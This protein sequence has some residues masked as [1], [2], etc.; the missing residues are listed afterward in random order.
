MNKFLSELTN[1]KKM[2]WGNNKFD[3][4]YLAETTLFFKVLQQID[5]GILGESKI[6]K[7]GSN[8]KR[9]YK[10]SINMNLLQSSM[11]S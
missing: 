6:L 2:Q 7:N 4:K 10:D 5:F 11:G 8:F 3:R 9:F 1:E